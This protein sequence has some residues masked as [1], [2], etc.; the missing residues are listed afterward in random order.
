M[1]K[2]NSKF[3]VVL[4]TKSLSLGGVSIAKKSIAT[5]L[6]YNEALKRVDSYIT[7]HYIRKDLPTDSQGWYF[8]GFAT[9]QMVGVCEGFGH[10]AD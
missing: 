7:K 6:S 4:F 9:R 3:S 1:K 10:L 8:T 5:N 2:T